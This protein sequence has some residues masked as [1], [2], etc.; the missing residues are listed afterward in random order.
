MDVAME[1][2][3]AATPTAM[4][5]AGATMFD[6]MEKNENGKGDT[7]ERSPGS[8]QR[9][10]EPHGDHDMIAGTGTDSAVPNSSTS[11]KPGGSPGSP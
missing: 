1:R 7:E 11:R 10:E 6:P 8:P 2:A 4:E 9:L 3:T 5:T